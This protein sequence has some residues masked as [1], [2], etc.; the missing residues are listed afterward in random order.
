MTEPVT[1]YPQFVT[2]MDALYAILARSVFQELVVTN[3]KDLARIESWIIGLARQRL[4]RTL[5]SVALAEE[6]TRA[7]AEELAIREFVLSLHERIQL[8]LA[9][10]S[11][12]SFYD[13][14]ADR[15]CSTRLLYEKTKLLDARD[16]SLLGTK[17]EL[18]SILE[19]DPWII[20][21][22][23]LVSTNTYL[24]GFARFRAYQQNGDAA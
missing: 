19:Q 13:R 20:T 6:F 16:A 22:Y 17:G 23:L 21:V 5:S 14:I 7:V 1:Q 10:E 2:D 9:L 3:E 4:L 12:P 15:M 24:D 11:E 18:Q 8:H